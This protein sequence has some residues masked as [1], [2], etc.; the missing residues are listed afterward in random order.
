MQHL[1]KC[2]TEFYFTRGHGNICTFTCENSQDFYDRSRKT[3][4]NH[5]PQ[6][7]H[8]RIIKI[9]S[10]SFFICLGLSSYIRTVL[11]T[12]YVCPSQIFRSR[13]KPD[14]WY[15][16]DNYS[17]V[18]SKFSV[19]RHGCKTDVSKQEVVTWRIIAAAAVTAVTRKCVCLL[20]F[21]RLCLWSRF[22]S[23]FPLC[24]HM[25]IINV[26]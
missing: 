17:I 2:I 10:I 23:S 21:G 25:N 3:N 1:F 19:P 4:F 9:I 12:I 15:T 14:F 18:V 6:K 24:N 8:L 7:N 13:W 5:A 26:D 22:V 11:L 20:R 16:V